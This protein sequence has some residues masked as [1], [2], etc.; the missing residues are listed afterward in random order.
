MVASKPFRS[1]SS[2]LFLCKLTISGLSIFNIR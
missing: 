1:G 2:N